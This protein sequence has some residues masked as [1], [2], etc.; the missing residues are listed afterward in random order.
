MAPYVRVAVAGGPTHKVSKFYMEV[1]E[2]FT[3]MS[4]I[5]TEVCRISTV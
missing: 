5:Y 2:V 3:K 4:K 1:C